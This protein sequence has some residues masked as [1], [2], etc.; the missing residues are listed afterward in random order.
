MSKFSRLILFPM[1]L[2]A[3]LLMPLGMG[4]AHAQQAPVLMSLNSQAP[5]PG[6]K[7]TVTHQHFSGVAA[8]MAVVELA[9]GEKFEQTP[10][11]VSNTQFKITVPAIYTGYNVTA[12]NAQHR[13][14]IQQVKQLY[15]KKGNLT[16]NK[17]PFN[18]VSFYPILDQ[19]N[20]ASPYVGDNVIVNGGNWDK[21]LIYYPSQMYWAVFE[22]LPG[23]FVKSNVTRPPMPNPAV[24]IPYMPNTELVGMFQVKVPDVY[25]GKPQAEQDAISKYTGKLYIYGLFGPNV[26]SNALPMQFKKRAQATTT[27]TQPPSSGCPGGKSFPNMTYMGQPS[28]AGTSALGA[29]LMCDAT[30]YYCCASAQGAN[31]KCGNGK[32][33][34]QP[35]CTQWGSGGGSNVGPLISNGIFYGCYK[36]NPR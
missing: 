18:I 34:F 21:N 12:K 5:A 28:C 7:L 4:V 23:K 8:W 1:I 25:A 9:N 36:T 27:T 6:A 10:Q 33:V 32:Y 30:G 13:Q 2:C 31:S 19:I 29:Y 15:V 11:Y 26:P 20:P 24:P 17:L 22:Y 35:G 16:S 3:V 14:R